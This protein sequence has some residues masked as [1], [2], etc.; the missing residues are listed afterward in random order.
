MIVKEFFHVGYMR[1]GLLALQK[2]GGDEFYSE[3]LHRRTFTK[4]TSAQKRVFCR[5]AEKYLAGIK[6]RALDQHHS[7]I[8]RGSQR[9]RRYRK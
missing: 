7:R 9:G 1:W 6:A 2:I 5:E 8:Q 3:I 4:F